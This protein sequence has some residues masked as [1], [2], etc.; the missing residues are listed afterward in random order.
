MLLD[1]SLSVLV[2]VL[3]FPYCI[4]CLVRVHTA[5]YFRSHRGS[6]EQHHNK[7]GP[8][9][10]SPRQAKTNKHRRIPLSM[11]TRRRPRSDHPD[12]TRR[13]ARKD[14]TNMLSLV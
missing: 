8:G 13:G 12:D 11:Q 2:V 5:C 14:H 7:Q 6:P 1:L 4:L 10:T 9:R 3:E